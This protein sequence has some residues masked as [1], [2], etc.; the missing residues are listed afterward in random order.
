MKQGFSIS[1]CFGKSQKNDD[2][3]AFRKPPVYSKVDICGEYVV[4]MGDFRTPLGRQ[5][6]LKIIILGENTEFFF[7]LYYR[8]RFR[9][10]LKNQT[11]INENLMDVGSPWT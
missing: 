8:G 2:R 7:F 11:K 4:Q 3:D 5:G 9:K 6:V 1:Q 10:S